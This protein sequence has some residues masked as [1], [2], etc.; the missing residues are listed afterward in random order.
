MDN[1]NNSNKLNFRI[2]IRCYI[3]TLEKSRILKELCK[4]KIS[5]RLLKICELKHTLT[6][7]RI[8]Q[9]DCVDQVFGIAI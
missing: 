1:V 8:D 9:I 3:N 4:F 7:F 6:P 5:Y 2:A